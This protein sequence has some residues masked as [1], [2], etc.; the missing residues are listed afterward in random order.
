VALW[1]A[2]A[3]LAPVFGSIPWYA[4]GVAAVV[5]VWLWSRHKILGTLFAALIFGAWLAL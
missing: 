5:A 3:A 1:S 4:Y 2:G